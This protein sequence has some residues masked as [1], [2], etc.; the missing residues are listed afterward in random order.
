M[1]LDFIEQLLGFV[2]SIRPIGRGFKRDEIRDG[3]FNRLS[4]ARI[5][6]YFF[7][8]LL[9]QYADL[10][11]ILNT[12]HQAFE[13]DRTSCIGID[14]VGIA[15]RPGSEA[16][17]DQRIFDPRVVCPAQET[18]EI[19]G[20]SVPRSIDRFCRGGKGKHVGEFVGTTHIIG[21]D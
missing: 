9:A 15:G 5:R 20:N 19:G 17:I 2:Q 21:G 10:F 14:D 6:V 7:R 3:F 11:R 16:R 18:I 4:L 8:I 1:K 12:F 13:A